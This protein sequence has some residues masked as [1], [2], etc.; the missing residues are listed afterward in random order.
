MRAYAKAA[1]IYQAE[2]LSDLNGR[3]RLSS[4]KP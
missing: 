2:V 4:I 3:R 1:R